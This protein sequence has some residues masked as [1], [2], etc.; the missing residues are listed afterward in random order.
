MKTV[1]NVHRLAGPARAGLT[2]SWRWIISCS[3]VLV[4][5]VTVAAIVVAVSVP[6]HLVMSGYRGNFDI[7]IR[8]ALTLASIFVFT[9]LLQQRYRLNRYLSKKGQV[10]EAFNVWNVT[11]V[12]FV[13]VGFMT[14]VIDD[15]SRAV[16]VLTYLTGICLVPLVRHGV[17]KVISLASK[18][19][20]ITGQRV[21]LI[22]REGDITSLMTRHQPWNSGMSIEEMMVFSEPK[23]GSSNEHRDELLT[24]DLAHA[25]HRARTAKPDGV[26]IALP[27]SERVR[28]E[29]CVEAFMTVPV[30]IHLAPEEVMDRFDNP[31]I[32]RIGSMASLELTPPPMTSPDQLVKR[33]LD[34]GGAATLLLLLVPLFAVIAIAIKLDGKGPIFFFQRRFGFNQEPFRIIKFRTM[35]AMDDGDVVVQAR[36]NDPRVTTVGRWLRRWNFDELPQL[37]NVLQGRMSL[38]G[39]R[40]HALAHDKE[41]EQKIALYA[42]RHN[43]KPGI[44]GWAQVHGM[45]GMTDTDDKMARRVAYDLWYIDNWNFWLDVMILFRTV[46]SRKA[47]RNA[48]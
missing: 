3:T 43:V 8:L 24:A 6:Y 38:V 12:A 10:L 34:F 16:V 14:R 40:P 42:R 29:R 1:S 13:A 30:S 9:N 23:P 27:W 18:T 47:Y 26:F 36:A 32:V 5:F 31:R 7:M 25:V 22:G 48:Q 20:R 4:D 37:L 11:M 35:N 46:F 33:I 41:F 45:R 2:R 28:I 15:Y 19:G 21:L 17:V 39:P 44:T